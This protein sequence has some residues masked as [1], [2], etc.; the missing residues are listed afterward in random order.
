MTPPTGLAPPP[1][2][3]AAPTKRHWKLT[4]DPD[5]YSLVNTDSGLSWHKPMYLEPA[6]YSTRYF[7]RRTE[8]VFQLSFKY[9][10]LS[11]PRDGALYAA[12]T[13][14]SFWEA[15]NARDS[16]PFRETNY[17]PELFYRFI[18]QD[19]EKWHHLG[20]DFGVEH[21]SNGKGLPNSR[22]WNRIYFA[23]FQAEDRHLIYFKVW[24]R[25]P[26]N[27]SKS[28]TDPARD[29]NPDIQ[30]YYGYAQLDYEQKFFGEQLAHLMAR[31]NVATG[32]GAISLN[33]SIP[34]PGNRF[35]WGFFFFN[36]YGD[37]LIDYNHADTRVGIALMLTR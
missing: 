34:G 7:G 14:K 15:Y 29:D 28:A 36:G 19:R 33:Y 21:N 17:N 9:K 8:L 4:A 37:S 27:E 24:W 5:T 11:Y 13:Q 10:L 18:P 16:R 35:F 31:Y 1:P 25:I 2:A 26:E 6:T 3:A 22:S 12:Y 23:P 30:D 20:L 32:R